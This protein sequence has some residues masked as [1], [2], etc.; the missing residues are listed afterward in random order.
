[1]KTFTLAVAAVA[2]VAAFGALAAAPA[3]HATS[4][5][6]G[7]PGATTSQ[8]TTSQAS[9]PASLVHPAAYEL[10]QAKAG[11][12]P[13]FAS[14]ECVTGRGSKV[15]FKRHGDVIWVQSTAGDA[16]WEN[17]LRNSTGWHK[18]RSGECT[19]THIGWGYCNKDFYE[20]SSKNILGGYGSGLRL[21]SCPVNTGYCSPQIWIRNNA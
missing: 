9:T 5:S 4:L 12:P 19:N 15:C 2:A 3:A 14:G 6:T 7:A 16:R 18:W 11:T 17:W 13:S 1:M 10:D 21:Q 8:A 20:D